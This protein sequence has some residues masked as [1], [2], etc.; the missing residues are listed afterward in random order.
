MLSLAI[1]LT[2]WTILIHR[3][4]LCMDNPSLRTNL[5]RGQSSIS[6]SQR[7]NSNCKLKMRNIFTSS[8][9]DDV[10]IASVNAL[11]IYRVH[12]EFQIQNSSTFITVIFKHQN[13]QYE[14]TFHR[15]QSHNRSSTPV[16]L[17]S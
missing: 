16:L 15:N 8:V 1:T 3:H 9:N 7:L 13:Y 4:S 6:N 17:N 10:F 14:T 12:S 2:T 11:H 5:F